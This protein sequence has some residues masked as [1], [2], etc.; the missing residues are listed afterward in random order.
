[1]S[2]QPTRRE[3]LAG[4]ALTALATTPILAGCAGGEDA[5]S[6]STARIT[7]QLTYLLDVTFA[8]WYL[9]DTEGFLKNERVSSRLLPYGANV[10]T[11]SAVVA[12]GRAEV[13]LGA[14]REVIEANLQGADLVVFGTQFQKSPGG[15]LSLAKNP[16]R[17]IQDVIGKRIGLDPSGKATLDVALDN[18]G[19]PHDYKVVNVSGDPQPLVDGQVDAMAVF[20]TSQ[21]I[22]LDRRGVANVAVTFNDLGFPSY[23]NVLIAR[24]KTLENDKDVLAR[25]LRAVIKGWEFNRRDLVTGAK[26]TFDLYGKDNSLDLAQQTEENKR[27]MPL[28]ESSLTDEKGLFQMSLE[29]IAGPQYEALRR[30]GVKPLP[31]VKSFVTLDVLDEA[32][33]GK[34]SLLE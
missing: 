16:V 19:L 33:Q 1:M 3:F 7:T 32:Y 31:D 23:E 28:M 5:P 34:T 18:A 9:A 4:V 21:P 24:R 22:T 10:P 13:G 6:G 20:I 2:G 30:A 8:G 15:L 27:Q 29:G 25:Y 17:K 14:I 11:T 26:R 12:G